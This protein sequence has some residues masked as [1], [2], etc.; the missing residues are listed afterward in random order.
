M[1]NNTVKHCKII[2]SL[3]NLD[4]EHRK[5]RQSKSIYQQKGYYMWGIK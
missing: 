5:D 3:S 1:S 2:H 4:K